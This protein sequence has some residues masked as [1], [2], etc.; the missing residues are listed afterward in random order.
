[1]GRLMKLWST[2]PILKVFFICLRVLRLCGGLPYSWKSSE[3]ENE[4][5]KKLSFAWED[6]EAGGNILPYSLKRDGN[7]VKEPPQSL[8]NA[9]A[10]EK[11]FPCS[12]KDG[13]TE[14]NKRCNNLRSAEDKRHLPNVLVKRRC[15][16]IMSWI[17]TIYCVS[18]YTYFLHKFLNKLLGDNMNVA[19]EEVAKDVANTIEVLAAVGLLWHMWRCS[20]RLAVMVAHL[21]NIITPDVE[22]ALPLQRDRMQTFTLLFTVAALLAEIKQL[23]DALPDAD[24]DNIQPG[25]RKYASFSLYFALKLIMNFSIAAMIFLFFSIASI[26]TAGYTTIANA[27]LTHLSGQT[28]WSC[29]PDQ[30]SATGSKSHLPTEVQ[31]KDS[32]K[33][34]KSVRNSNNDV[35]CVFKTKEPPPLLDNERLSQD[36]AEATQMLFTLHHH[37]RRFNEY[38][39]VPIIL[40]TI[41]S[42]TTIIIIIFNL[43]M[44]V[45]V[46]GKVCRTSKTLCVIKE[47]L[48]LCLIT[49]TP[50]QISIQREKIRCAL[51]ALRVTT[52]SPRSHDQ[53]CS[54]MEVMSDYPNFNVANFFTLAKNNLIS[55]VGFITTYLVILMQFKV[56]ENES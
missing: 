46:D 15:W 18:Q 30:P 11:K 34:V 16:V 5:D 52:V 33:T 50:D 17:F 8:E 49:F 45:I 41:R 47:M 35:V 3:A 25:Y 44:K 40:I 20:T 39:S 29:S 13:G 4:K 9:R 22:V 19:T 36:A 26:S 56:S 31:P 55:V 23:L 21:S 2:K 1:M 14:K 53:L 48:F 10:T 6:G 42:I 37:Q 43:M 7:K 32:V 24:S 27:F 54:V 38:F 28:V 51:T 12:L